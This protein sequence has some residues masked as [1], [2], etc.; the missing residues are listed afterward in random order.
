MLDDKR[1]HIFL[2]KCG[3]KHLLL[4]VH[5]M[6]QKKHQPKY[7]WNSTEVPLIFLCFLCVSLSVMRI[8]VS[9]LHWFC[10]YAESVY[11]PQCLSV[12]CGI[13][14]V[15]LPSWKPHFLWSIGVLFILACLHTILVCLVLFNKKQGLTRHRSMAHPVV[16][17]YISYSTTFAEHSVHCLRRCLAF[18]WAGTCLFLSLQLEVNHTPP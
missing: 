5:W 1:V 17:R 3:G 18:G 6:G 7:Y 13:V 2:G 11:F 4:N 16:F 14:S 12:F 9:C 8:F 10:P 15:S